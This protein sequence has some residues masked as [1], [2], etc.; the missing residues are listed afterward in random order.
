MADSCSEHDDLPAQ[1]EQRREP[2]RA[3]RHVL[4]QRLGPQ[5]EGAQAHL[6]DH[7][8]DPERDAG[9]EQLLEPRDAARPVARVERGAVGD[10]G[11]GEVGGQRQGSPARATLPVL[12]GRSSAAA[13]LAI[14]S[15]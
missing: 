4:A 11:I 15:A 9:L 1:A 8:L 7:D 5:I 14:E 2:A 3:D 10:V 13:L 12:G 6:A